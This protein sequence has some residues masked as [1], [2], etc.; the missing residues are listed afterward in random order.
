LKI[1]GVPHEY[2][3]IDGVKE[4]VIEIMLNFKK[5]RFKFDESV[6]SIQWVPQRFKGIGKYIRSMNEFLTMADI[7][8]I[9]IP[10]NSETKG[11]IGDKEIAAM[12]KT[13]YIINTARG[14]IIN[15][16]ALIKA[17]RNNEIAGA[18]IDVFEIE[19]TSENNEL[20]KLSNTI[21]TPHIAFKTVEALNRRAE[22]TIKN[23]KG[24]LSK[25]EINR[26]GV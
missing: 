11:L 25:N 19:P 7:I 16:K 1:K 10:L 5:L 24:F 22:V 4:D 20:L 13:A 15:E 12:K 3:V 17:L 14:P 18:G 23:I 21:V 6:E 9:H 2:H 26:V 8:S